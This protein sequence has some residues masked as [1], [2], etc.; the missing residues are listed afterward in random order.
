V[1]LVDGGVPEHDAHVVALGLAEREHKSLRE[2]APHVVRLNVGE[3]DVGIDRQADSHA[4]SFPAQTVDN[5]AVGGHPKTTDM[6]SHRRI[7]LHSSLVTLRRVKQ[8]T[9]HSEHITIRIPL[10]TLDEH[11]CVNQ[12]RDLVGQT[13]HELETTT[14]VCNTQ[15][16]DSFIDVF[17][18]EA[19]AI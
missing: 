11:A 3:Q 8:T 12:D 18:A 1:S 7:E 13:A 17:I 16:C 5:S 19:L 10:H 9:S 2:V 14:L 4:I 6:L 15:L